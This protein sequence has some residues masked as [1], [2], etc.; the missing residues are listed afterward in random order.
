M[1]QLSCFD[2][3]AI[4]NVGADGRDDRVRPRRR[5]II[6]DCSARRRRELAESTSAT[7]GTS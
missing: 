1:Q 2:D 4:D 6:P 3:E 7:T 5:R